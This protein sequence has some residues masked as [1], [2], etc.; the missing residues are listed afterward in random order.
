MHC[1][2]VTYTQAP[3]QMSSS[4][5]SSTY[6]SSLASSSVTFNL[7]GYH[8]RQT[9]NTTLEIRNFSNFTSDYAFA[10]FSPPEDAHQIEFDF[11]IFP[12][13]SH[14]IF[15][16]EVFIYLRLKKNTTGEDRAVVHYR[17]SILGEGGERRFVQGLFLLIWSF[18][19]DHWS[20]LVVCSV[21]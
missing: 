12:K 10:H 1:S 15:S 14:R 9:A 18:S 19:F 2:P 8:V 20:Y 7:A 17:V 5:S 6:S 21:L 16:P 13:I 11:S 4:A 3:T